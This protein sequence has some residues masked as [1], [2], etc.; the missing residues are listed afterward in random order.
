MNH[1]PNICVITHKLEL[2]KTLRELE[3]ELE[4]QKKPI[5]LQ[6]DAF[7]PK[8]YRL[9]VMSDEI[10]FIND[11]TT[12]I[13]IYKPRNL[14]QGRGIRLISDI[15]AFKAEFVRSKKFYLGEF[16][17]NHM[18][19]YKPELSPLEG[20]AQDRPS[21]YGELKQDGLIQHYIRPLLLNRKKFD[22]RCFLF[23]NSFPCVALFNPGYL[24]L[25]IEDYCEEDIEDEQRLMVHLTNN[26]FQN[27][28]ELYKQKKEDTIARWELI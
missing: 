11:E 13:W 26:C 9:D 25:T 19:H 14:N 17:L 7:V 28:H 18:L 5:A 27:K 15:Q 3:A 2:L 1:I 21:K 22:I 20:Q 12:G 6:V 4:Q 23:Y 8:T 16:A 24:R 10:D